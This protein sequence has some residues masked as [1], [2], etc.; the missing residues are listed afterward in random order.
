MGRT[1]SLFERCWPGTNECQPCGKGEVGSPS[2]HGDPGLLEGRQGLGGAGVTLGVL[3]CEWWHGFRGSRARSK[4]GT[5][6]GSGPSGTAAHW[7]LRVFG[8]I[9]QSHV[10]P[11]VLS[12]AAR[13]L[14]RATAASPSDITQ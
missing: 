1:V 13:C 5:Y 12:Y 9:N 3:V 11:T 8:E 6:G 10:G 2:L 7:G 14:R 4:T